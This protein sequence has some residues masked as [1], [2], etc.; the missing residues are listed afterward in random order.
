MYTI[1]KEFTF[2]ASHE[3]RQLP[4]DHPCH[5]NHGHNYRVILVLQSPT[6][7]ALGMVVDYHD[8]NLFKDYLDK[9]FD[10]KLLNDVVG[11][12]PTAE[13]LAEHFYTYCKMHWPE[14]LMVKVSET[15]KTWAA[16][17]E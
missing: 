15:D 16:F 13:N 6:V 4:A 8:L 2:S 7:N 12:H 9:N 1:S 10:H 3:L 14:T 11:Y 17:H 5:N